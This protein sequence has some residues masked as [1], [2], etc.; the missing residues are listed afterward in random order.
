MI[1]KDAGLIFDVNEYNVA[2]LIKV[3]NVPGTELIIPAFVRG[4]M[5]KKIGKR[6]FTENQSLVNIGIPAS[7]NLI[8]EE[9]FAKCVRLRNIK[10]YV[11]PEIAPICNLQT[12]AF[13][14]C[15]RLES[16]QF[17]NKVLLDGPGVFQG[18]VNLCDIKG[19]FNSLLAYTFSGCRSLRHL[20]LFGKSFISTSAFN[21]C[22]V[23]NKLTI[24]GTLSPKTSP[25]MIEKLQELTI[26]CYPDS[27]FVDWVYDGVNIEIISPP[28][29]SPR[30]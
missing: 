29:E 14:A 18:C 3:D 5:V 17:P 24:T 7:V 28:N 12:D 25:V 21:G 19:K 1:V 16:I 22:T 9:A 26:A 20:T 2:T 23:L 8:E 6:A 4:A 27:D 11:T 10:F 30:P 15:F 13:K